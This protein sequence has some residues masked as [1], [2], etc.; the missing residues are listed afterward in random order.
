MSNRCCNFGAEAPDGC[1]TRLGSCGRVAVAN[2]CW[3]VTFRSHTTLSRGK[4]S[5]AA[6]IRWIWCGKII[7]FDFPAGEVAGGMRQDRVQ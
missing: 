2:H 1:P 7:V 5:G 4:W 3:Q 6:T